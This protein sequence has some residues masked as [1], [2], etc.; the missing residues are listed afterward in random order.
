MQ[1]PL[2]EVIRSPWAGTF[3]RLFSIVEQD[4]L[5]VSP[6][7]KKQSTDQFLAVLKERGIE[8]RV[9]VTVLTNLSPECALNGSTDL[10]AFLQLSRDLP[11]FELTHLPSLHAKIYI[12]DRQMAVVTSGNLTPSG[13]GGNLEYGVAFASEAAVSEIRHDFENYLL[14]GARIPIEDVEGLVRE[15]AELKRAFVAAQRSIRAAARR[16]FKEKLQAANEQ[17]LRHRARGKTTQAILSEAIIFLLAKAPLRTTELYPLIQQVHPDICDDSID[18]VIDG[19]N[20]GKRWKHYVRNA[21]QFLKR[22]GRIQHDGE[23]WRLAVSR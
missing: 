10:E 17:L 9:R 19:V 16:A 18:R 4:L 23:F 15:T 2:P 22:T 13:I 14:L 6:F 5:L 1:A 12:A 11:R 20:F 3:V 21:Q 7:V 8:R